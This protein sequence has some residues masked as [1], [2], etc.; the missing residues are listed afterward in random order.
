MDKNSEKQGYAA[1]EELKAKFEV[2]DA[3]FEGVKTAN[4]WK[5]GKMMTELAFTEAVRAF[6]DAPMDGRRNKNVQ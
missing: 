5:T 3:V 2:P 6:K 4:A 1:I